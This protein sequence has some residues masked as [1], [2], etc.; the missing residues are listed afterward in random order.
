MTHQE[1]EEKKLLLRHVQGALAEAEEERFVDHYT[2]CRSCYEQVHHYISENNL[3]EEY[4][5][6]RLPAGEQVFFEKH[7]LGCETCF[8]ELKRN[9]K[10]LTALQGAVRE[11]AA[12]LESAAPPSPAIPPVAEAGGAPEPSRRPGQAKILR[13]FGS[14]PALAAAAVLAVILLAIP[15]WRGMFKVPE[16]ERQL[17]QPSADVQSLLLQESRERARGPEE[18][19]GITISGETGWALLQCAIIEQSIDQPRYRAEILDHSGEAVWQ[20]EAVLSAGDA[21]VLNILCRGSFFSPG[22]YFL[23]VYEL[24]AALQPTGKAF[25]FPF[26]V[27]VAK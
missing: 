1:V 4:L 9:E 6:G 13:F 25:D 15:A 20:S 17:R 23:K 12:E 2:Y 16:L 27:S 21:G 10:F 5:F 26:R 8:K 18:A 24:N 22:Q 3:I 7:Y 19:P 11:S 14:Y